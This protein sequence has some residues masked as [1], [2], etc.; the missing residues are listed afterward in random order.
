[1]LIPHLYPVFIAGQYSKNDVA[2]LMD[3]ITVLNTIPKTRNTKSIETE[4]TQLNLN[5]KQKF[6]HSMSLGS[7]STQYQML[8]IYIIFQYVNPTKSWSVIGMVNLSMQIFI[9]P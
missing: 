7:E 8:K 2:K 5:G 1:M 3:K 9:G 6:C 4:S